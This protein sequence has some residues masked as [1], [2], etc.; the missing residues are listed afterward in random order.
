VVHV[1]D[2]VDFVT[3]ESQMA[4]RCAA[5]YIKSGE[6]QREGAIALKNGDGVTYTVP[7][8]IRLPNVD[9]LVEVSFRVN[10]TCGASAINVTSG[11]ETLAS[12]KR[13]RMAP[14]EMEKVSIPLKLLKKVQNN[15]MM[16]SIED[17]EVK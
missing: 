4:G 10:R 14:G 12:Y 3:K 6:V 17:R 1:H 11:G 13:E 7:Q 16:V 9:K 8:S 5:V 2:L 15:E